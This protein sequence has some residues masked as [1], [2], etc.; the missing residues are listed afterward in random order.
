MAYLLSTD[1][2]VVLESEDNEEPITVIGL[3]D[4]KEKLK[5]EKNNKKMIIFLQN[6]IIF[7]N[8]KI[9]SKQKGTI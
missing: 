3:K 4:T 5:E 7:H 8:S 2:N 6:L 9:E 1:D